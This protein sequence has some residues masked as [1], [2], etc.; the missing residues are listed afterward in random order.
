MSQ[1]TRSA[2]QRDR[3]GLVVAVLS[4]RNESSA[5]TTESQPCEID[6]CGENRDGR[7]WPATETVTRDSKQVYVCSCHADGWDD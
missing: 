1:D 3:A 5:A 4:A 7:P 2:A 6:T